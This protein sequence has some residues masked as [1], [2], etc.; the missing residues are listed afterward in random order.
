MH[1][2]YAFDNIMQSDVISALV[3]LDVESYLDA[4]LMGSVQNGRHQII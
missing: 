4:V 2:N 3:G 1:V